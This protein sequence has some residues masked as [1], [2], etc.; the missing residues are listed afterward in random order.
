MGST[1]LKVPVF[2]ELQSISCALE[3]TACTSRTKI[4]TDLSIVMYGVLYFNCY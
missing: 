1:I 3:T 4:N 2:T